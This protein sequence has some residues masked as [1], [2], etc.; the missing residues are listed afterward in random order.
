MNTR[1]YIASTASLDD[2]TTFAALYKTVPKY[3][4][5][6]IDHYSDWKEKKLSLGVG[7]LLTRALKNAGINESKLELCHDENGKPY[8][9]NHEEIH[10][11]LSHSEE[12]VMCIISDE[13]AGCDVEYLPENTETDLE[14]WT[15]MESFCKATDSNML[16]LMKGNVSFKGYNFRE[17]KEEDKYLF[18]ICSKNPIEDNQIEMVKEF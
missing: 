13:P 11:S 6:K 5:A 4:Q 3:R 14:S 16:D 7:L 2:E 17:I 1:V 12:R 10:F 8:F 9:K 18:V 15:K